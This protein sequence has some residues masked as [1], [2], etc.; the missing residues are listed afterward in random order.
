MEGE[1]DNKVIIWRIH[2]AVIPI[3]CQPDWASSLGNSAWSAILRN[4]TLNWYPAHL[5]I[6]GAQRAWVHEPFLLL[7]LFRDDWHFVPHMKPRVFHLILCKA[8]KS[9]DEKLRSLGS[10]WAGHSPF[11]VPPKDMSTWQKIPRLAPALSGVDLNLGG[12]SWTISRTL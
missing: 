12:K 5:L 10:W 11:C 4:S 9:Y 7:T 2:L 6:K 8:F 3:W 1:R